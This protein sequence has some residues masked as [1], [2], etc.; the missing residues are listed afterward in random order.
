MQ[1]QMIESQKS[2]NITQK[3][4]TE[5]D[6]ILPWPAPIIIHLL[7]ELQQSDL[8]YMNMKGLE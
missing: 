1:E 4:E 6:F 3:T 5:H 2:Y 7:Y 8:Y